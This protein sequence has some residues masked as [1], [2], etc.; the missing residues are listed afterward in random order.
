MQSVPAEL[1]VAPASPTLKA[2]LMLVFTR[3]VAAANCFPATLQCVFDCVYGESVAGPMATS[4]KKDQCQVCSNL[5]QTST[6]NRL[7]VVSVS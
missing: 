7:C 2:R 5:L 4:S 3:S 6:H 1:R